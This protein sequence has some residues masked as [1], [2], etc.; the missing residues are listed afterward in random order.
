MENPSGHPKQPLFLSLGQHTLAP[1]RSHHGSRASSQASWPLASGFRKLRAERTKAGR[2]GSAPAP[3]LACG[4]ARLQ[5]AES[6]ARRPREMHSRGAT[7]GPT[8]GAE[9]AQTRALKTMRK[10]NDSAAT[11]LTEAR[12]HC[13]AP[14]KGVTDRLAR[15][16]HLSGAAAPKPVAALQTLH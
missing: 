9:R 16:P 3:H 15:R 4:E 10:P 14:Q 11:S 12:R 2:M 6:Q 8:T 7:A 1:G 13:H 5:D